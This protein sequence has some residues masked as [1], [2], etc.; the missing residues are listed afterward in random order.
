VGSY[1]SATSREWVAA[2]WLI[3]GIA[4]VAILGLTA[5]AALTIGAMAAL[6]LLANRA[7]AHPELTYFNG[8]RVVASISPTGETFIGQFFVLPALAG[9]TVFSWLLGLTWLLGARE[10]PQRRWLGFLR[11]Y[12][13]FA[14]GATIHN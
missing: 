9:A 14:R 6:T 3:V 2:F 8:L 10:W 13:T 12:Q 5:E 11:R 1:V 7:C 4:V